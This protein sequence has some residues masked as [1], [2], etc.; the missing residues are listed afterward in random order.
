MDTEE[1]KSLGTF[2]T[3]SFSTVFDSVSRTISIL[4]TTD[5]LIQSNSHITNA[6]NFYKRFFFILFFS[7]L[8]NDDSH[9]YFAFFFVK[10]LEENFR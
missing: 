7:V 2:L 9:I 6:L 10:I 5:K 4:I 1:M 8:N 3:A